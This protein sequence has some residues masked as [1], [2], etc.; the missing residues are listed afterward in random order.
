MQSTLLLTALYLAVAAGVGVLWW[1]AGVDHQFHISS[2]NVHMIARY[3]PAIVGTVTVLLFQQTVREFLRI[4][5]F[6]AMADQKGKPTPGSIPWKS[7]SGGFFPWQDIFVTPGFTSFLSLTMQFLVSFVVSLKVALL[8]TQIH[9]D[10]WTLTVRTIPAAA[11]VGGYVSMA[12]YNIFITMKLAG[13]STGLK[14]DPVSIAD[15]VALF[16]KCNAK[17]YF[18]PLELRHNVKAK[19]VMSDE[20][21]FRLG[22]WDKRKTRDENETPEIVY[23]IGVAFGDRRKSPNWVLR[24]QAKRYSN[25]NARGRNK[26]MLTEPTLMNEGAVRTCRC[27]KWP[28][29]SHSRKICAC[30]QWPGCEHPARGCACPEWPKCEH[31]PYRHNPGVARW[32]LVTCVLVVWAALVV[33]IYALI[34]HWPQHG[35]DVPNNWSLPTDLNLNTTIIGHTI[36][37]DLTSPSDPKATLLVYAILFRSVP[38]YVAG[39]F[40]NTIIPSIDL[41]M[42]FMQ[43]FVEMLPIVQQPGQAAKTVLLDY[44]TLSSLQVPLTAYAN[45]HYKVS[46]FSTLNTISP[47]FPIFVGGLLTVAPTPNGEHVHL[48]F[49]LSAYIGIIVSLVLYSISLPFGYPHA[50]RLLPRQFYSMADLMAMCHASRLMASPHLDITDSQK[51][52]TKAHMEA[53]ILNSRDEFKFGMYLGR[54]ERLHIGFDISATEKPAGSGIIIPTKLVH[55]IPRASDKADIVAHD[56][57]DLI[58]RNTQR[59]DGHREAEEG[60]ARGRYQAP[61]E[62]YEMGQTSATD[63]FHRPAGTRPHRVG[64]AQQSPGS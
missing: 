2:E 32:Y 1:R 26:A 58:R 61:S 16:S 7:V 41:N 56:R 8:A 6:I 37:L 28:I 60:R 57:R 22:Y 15:F 33:S 25:E 31:Y 48:S 59:Q 30:N 12:C 52:P 21:W 46:W 36:N 54:D 47:L 13:K 50:H 49:S 9:N 29:C 3:F 20:Q 55:W 43:P 23:G 24:K 38:T 63:Q 62:Q 27:S 5:P 18:E 14:W 64:F 39:L 17:E 10:A 4:K 34:R 19:H 44:I 11:L 45:E 51:C 53:R 40:I 35:F 42:R